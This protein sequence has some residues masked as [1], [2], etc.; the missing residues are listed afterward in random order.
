[1]IEEYGFSVSEKKLIELAKKTQKILAKVIKDR[2]PREVIKDIDPREVIKEMDLGGVIKDKDQKKEINGEFLA[3]IIIEKDFLKK[4]L[5]FYPKTDAEND[6][7]TELIEELVAAIKEKEQ[8]AVIKEEKL[9]Q[10]I[11]KFALLIQ[12]KI[13]PDIPGLNPKNEAA[14]I[15]RL[16]PL[17]FAY[18]IALEKSRSRKNE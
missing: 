12:D 10:I 1:M 2:D 16:G 13:T 8:S 6:D 7:L 14:M 18:L 11:K 17:I 4:I 3:N 5:K 9:A 15:G